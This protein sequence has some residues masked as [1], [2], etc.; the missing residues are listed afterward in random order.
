M[1]LW[2]GGKQ[3]ESWLRYPIFEYQRNLNATEAAPH[4]N[5]WLES[6]TIANKNGK[7]GFEIVSGRMH[8]TADL[9]RTAGFGGVVYLFDELETVATLLLSVRQ[10]YLSYEFLNL[11]V[12]GR[13]HPYCLFAFA[14]TP[15]FGLKIESDRIHRD[16]Y[17]VEYPDGCRFIQKWHESSVDLV[18]LRQI[19]RSEVAD[20]CK[21]LC[22]YHE[23]AF[24]WDSGG[25]FSYNFIGR[26]LDQAERLNM[27][28]R[29]V[30]RSFVH[31]LDIC[32]QHPHVNIEGTLQGTQKSSP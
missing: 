31:L 8:A 1:L 24:S 13:K 9:L 12:D 26:F 22:T 28:I 27:G 5:A 14:A 25:R 20:L 11:L 19:S 18:R 30:V 2:L 17:A 29:E 16:H 7:D 3:T 21:R 15:D 10:R 32:E 4:L 23:Q 6:R